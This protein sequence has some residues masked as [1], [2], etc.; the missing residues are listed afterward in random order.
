MNGLTPHPGPLPVEGRGR[1]R[2]RSGVAKL[3]EHKHRVAVRH[4]YFVSRDA[5]RIAPLKERG[6]GREALVGRK[7]IGACSFVKRQ[8]EHILRETHAK[9]GLTGNSLSEGA[10]AFPEGKFG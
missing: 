8:M 4:C 10:V 5:H 7:R 1:R 2:Q 6:E 9:A 3:A